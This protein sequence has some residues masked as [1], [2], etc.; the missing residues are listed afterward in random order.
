MG[1]DPA[2]TPG[3]ES[4]VVSPRLFQSGCQIEGRHYRRSHL[5]STKQSGLPASARLFSSGSR[6]AKYAQHV[7][8]DNLAVAIL[9]VHQCVLWVRILQWKSRRAIPRSISSRAH[10]GRLVDRKAFRRELHSVFNG[11][12]RG[13]PPPFNRQQPHLWRFPL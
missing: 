1:I 2:I 9:P 4:W 3:L 6:P 12:E 13:K 5:L 8:R 10:L 11:A 7:I